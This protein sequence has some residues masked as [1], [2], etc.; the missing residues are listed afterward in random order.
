MVRIR[1]QLREVQHGLER[2]IETLA[3]WLKVINIGLV[4]MGVLVV[5]GLIALARKHRRRIR[6]PRD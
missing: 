1:R 2:D 3:A 6:V 4:P 5:A